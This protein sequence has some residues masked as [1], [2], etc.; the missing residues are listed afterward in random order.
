M[1]EAKHLL[2]R[3]VALWDYISAR[4][5]ED[6][7]AF[8]RELDAADGQLIDDVRRHLA[9]VRAPTDDR[10]AKCRGTGA[11]CRR[12]L[13]FAVSSSTVG[14]E[15][16]VSSRQPADDPWAHLQDGAWASFY[17]H[18]VG[19]VVVLALIPIALVWLAYAT[20]YKIVTG[21]SP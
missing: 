7:V 14:T 4:S 3:V 15:R 11:V 21:D 6:A 18:A 5:H 2:R 8:Q 9:G 10:C 12:S 1:S 17:A 20:A 13:A 19:W 16:V